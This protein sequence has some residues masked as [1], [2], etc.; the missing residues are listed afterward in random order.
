MDSERSQSGPRMKDKG[1]RK[2]ELRCCRQIL[3]ALTQLTFNISSG[4]WWVV[5]V[6]GVTV[7]QNT[8]CRHDMAIVYHPIPQTDSEVPGLVSRLIIV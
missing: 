1:R 2:K 3:Q 4:G 7:Y 8:Y 5:V 6:Q